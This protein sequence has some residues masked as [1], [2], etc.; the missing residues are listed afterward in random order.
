MN[1]VWPV[2]RPHRSS[3][4]V[5]AIRRPHIAE[6]PGAASTPAPLLAY[7]SDQRQAE[8]PR[9]VASRVGRRV[10]RRPPGTSSTTAA[11]TAGQKTLHDRPRAF[12]SLLFVGCS[13]KLPPVT[14]PRP[15]RA[16]RVSS[17]RRRHGTCGGF[18]RAKILNAACLAQASSRPVLISTTP[19]A[20]EKR[21]ILGCGTTTRSVA[22]PLA[23]RGY[24]RSIGSQVLKPPL[25]QRG[26]DRITAWRI[27]L[28]PYGSTGRFGGSGARGGIGPPSRGAFNTRRARPRSRGRHC[29]HSRGGT[30]R[31]CRR[32]APACRKSAEGPRAGRR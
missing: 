14:R 30:A 25:L 9:T 10:I 22:R 3:D 20:G 18:T 32:R 23:G 4:R 2:G 21:S 16:A 29:R 19:G 31:A 26:L 12:G 15:L 24:R 8:P 28:L 17:T 11:M 13:L 27:A 1:A 5:A 7:T 6:I